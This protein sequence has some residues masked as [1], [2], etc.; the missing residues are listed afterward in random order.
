VAGGNGTGQRRDRGIDPLT[1]LPNEQFALQ[2]FV[3]DRHY[4]L[5]LL[6]P[7]R[8]RRVH[9]DNRDG[10]VQLD[11][12][13]HAFDGFPETD[14]RSYGSICRG[15]PTSSRK[16]S[17]RAPSIHWM[18]VMARASSSCPSDGAARP[19]RQRGHHVQARCHAP[20]VHGRAAGTLPGGRRIGDAKI[21][22]PKADGMAD[23]WVFVDGQLKFHRMHLRP[24]DGTVSL[25]VRSGPADRFLTPSRPTPQRLQL[26]HG[27]LGDPCCKWRQP[28]E[29]ENTRKEDRRW[30]TKCLGE[31]GTDRLIRRQNGTDF[32]MSV[33]RDGPIS[34]SVLARVEV[35]GRCSA[36]KTECFVC[37]LLFGDSVM[38][39]SISASIVGR[40]GCGILLAA[41]VQADTILF[42]DT[43]DGATAGSDYGLNDGLSTRLTGRW[44][45]A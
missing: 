3:G 12:A 25:D 33:R 22:S 23:L 11:S 40:C 37:N 18:Y 6:E 29:V 24:Q 20:D 10:P 45:V 16:K 39:K 19:L 34:K 36:R 13:R 9:P 2:M 8:R 38:S 44:P 27:G 35:S 14:G 7:A 43:F 15:R 32:Q 26:G 17:S 31:R 5:N 4:S 30:I 1:G 28:N 42:R 41:S 21:W